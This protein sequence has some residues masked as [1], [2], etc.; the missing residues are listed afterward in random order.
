[1]ASKLK[2]GAKFSHLA[3]VMA[4]ENFEPEGTLSDMSRSRSSVKIKGQSIVQSEEQGRRLCDCDPTFG[5]HTRA[6]ILV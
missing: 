2:F 4:Q 5:I 6:A 3:K 1:M